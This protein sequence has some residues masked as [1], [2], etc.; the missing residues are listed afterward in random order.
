MSDKVF[1]NESGVT[2]TEERLLVPG[3]SFKIIDIDSVDVTGTRPS[4]L[5]SIL[6]GL[7][8][9]AIWVPQ[10]DTWWVGYAGLG[11]VAMAWIWVRR[12]KTRYS[13][14]LS[15]GDGGTTALESQDKPLVERVVEALK[16]AMHVPN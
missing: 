4:R 16:D 10:S 3:R 2:V 12:L 11:I 13:I 7:I 15:T 6:V 1:L 5:V 9:F 14:V 8:G